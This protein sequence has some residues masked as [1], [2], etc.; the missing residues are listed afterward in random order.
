M[1]LGTISLLNQK[2][3]SIF[4]AI[5]GGSK[6]KCGSAVQPNL[7]IEVFSVAGKVIGLRL[8][9]DVLSTVCT[10]AWIAAR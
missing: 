9:Y 8:H 2:A 10:S 6:V 1:S 5:G 4:P 7:K 3:K